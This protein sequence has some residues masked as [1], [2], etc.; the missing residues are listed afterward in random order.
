MDK[1]YI[2][3]GEGH[4]DCCDDG[5][6]WNACFGVYSTEEK[7]RDR[8]TE[9]VCNDVYQLFYKGKPMD[10][11]PYWHT[12]YSDYECYKIEVADIDRN[13]EGH[14]IYDNNW[15]SE[16]YSLD[17]VKEQQERLGIS[18]HREYERKI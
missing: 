13:F 7:A 6:G 12:D 9:C 18:S 15:D 14:Y 1:V 16:T 8:V 4:W 2:V 5:E 10:S 11:K 3:K 17:W